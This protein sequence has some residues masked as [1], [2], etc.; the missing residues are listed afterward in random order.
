MQLMPSSSSVARSSSSIQRFSSEYD[1]WWMT[2]GVPSA[3]RIA[4]A[5]AVL[6]AEYDEIP[7]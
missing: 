2:N 5:S 4:A 7:T 6:T 3:R 1:G